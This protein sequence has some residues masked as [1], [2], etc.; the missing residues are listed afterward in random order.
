MRGLE[1]L[2]AWACVLCSGTAV[3]QIDEAFVTAADDRN[4]WMID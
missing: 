4:E 1:E 2:V 3:K